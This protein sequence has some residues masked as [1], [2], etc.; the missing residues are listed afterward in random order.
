VD[1][2]VEVVVLRDGKRKTLR[3][4]V[5][6]LPQ[7]ELGELAMQSEKGPAAFGLAVQDLNPELAQQLGLDTAEGVLITSITPG[8]PADDAQL[9]RG[10][11]I[12]EVDRS[13]IQDVGDLRTQLDAADD[14]ALFLVRRGDSTI[15]IPIKRSTG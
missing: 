7:P 2:T 8:S 12:L 9:R 5:G 3:A 4:D 14:G 15:F 6:E 13:A 1:K 11:V 10:D